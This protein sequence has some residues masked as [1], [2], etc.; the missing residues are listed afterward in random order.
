MLQIV[1]FQKKFIEI[2]FISVW[3]HEKNEITLGAL[4]LHVYDTD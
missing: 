3:N 1:E 2:L 4:F